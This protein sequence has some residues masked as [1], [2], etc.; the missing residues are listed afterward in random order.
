MYSND[1][2]HRKRDACVSSFRPLLARWVQVAGGK[3]LSG[4]PP[5]VMR[6]GVQRGRNAC[7]VG[8]IL[9]VTGR[10]PNEANVAAVGTCKL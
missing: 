3:R 10:S 9:E 6:G 7:Y 2:L 5:E 1:R 4:A 8:R